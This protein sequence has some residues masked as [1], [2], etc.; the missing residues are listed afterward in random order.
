MKLIKK[1]VNRIS[2]YAGKNIVIKGFLCG[3]IVRC[4]LVILKGRFASFSLSTGIPEYMLRR[5]PYGILSCILYGILGALIGA[6]FHFI[7]RKI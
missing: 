1:T 6:L 3:V 7:R 4:L 2:A 5:I